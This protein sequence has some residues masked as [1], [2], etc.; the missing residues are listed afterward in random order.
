MGNEVWRGNSSISKYSCGASTRENFLQIL[1]IK[2]NSTRHSSHTT[3]HF[4]YCVRL[5]KW[6]VCTHFG[7]GSPSASHSIINGFSVSPYDATWKSISSAIGCLIIRGGECTVKRIIRKL[8]FDFDEWCAAGIG[9]S[10]FNVWIYNSWI[11]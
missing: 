1:S 8:I 3:R 5:Q 11:G 6:V 10:L 7:A 9:K 2:M 4:Y